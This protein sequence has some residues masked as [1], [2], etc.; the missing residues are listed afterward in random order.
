MQIILIIY[1]IKKEKIMDIYTTPQMKKKQKMHEPE[2]ERNPTV[3]NG[4]VLSNMTITK[5]YEPKS[6]TLV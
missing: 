1:V 5:K 4:Q 2:F 3:K 6:S